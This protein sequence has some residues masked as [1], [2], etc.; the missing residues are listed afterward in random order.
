MNKYQTLEIYYDTKSGL[1]TPFFSLQA[2]GLVTHKRGSA[3]RIKAL[4]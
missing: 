3:S 4:R 1:A 2:L